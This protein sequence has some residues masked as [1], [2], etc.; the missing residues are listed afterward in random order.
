MIQKKVGDRLVY[1]FVSVLNISKK[2][3]IAAMEHTPNEV[4][5]WISGFIEKDIKAISA[6]RQT[7]RRMKAI[8]GFDFLPT[9]REK[10]MFAC[11]FGIKGLFDSTLRDFKGTLFERSLEELFDPLTVAS[12]SGNRYMV[13]EILIRE[14]KE[15][16][17]IPGRLL[18][19]ER[20]SKWRLSGRKLFLYEEV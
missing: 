14:E 3:S 13:R 15:L 12:E 17:Q 18:G 6:F 1:S 20:E 8:A 5:K 11:K 16:D 4:V 9:C 19:L 10:L 2:Y 7:C